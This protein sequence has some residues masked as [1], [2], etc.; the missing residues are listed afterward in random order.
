MG[1]FLVRITT[2]LV[3]IY[4][5]GTFLIA[6]LC[7]ENLFDDHYVLLFEL[8]VVV[9]TFSEGKYHCKYMKYTALSIFL[10][11]TLTRL[12]YMFDFMSV[13]AHNLIP[14]GILALGIGTSIT[15]AIMHF[16]RVMKLKKKKNY[17]NKESE[18][19]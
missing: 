10:A 19:R 1:K 2:I 9:C 5:V 17:V 14:I 7:G 13:S 6:Q 18:N 4:F 3:A 11:D 12:D 8:C 15:K 16:V